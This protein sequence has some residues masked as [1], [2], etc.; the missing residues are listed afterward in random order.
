MKI[1]FLPIF[2]FGLLFAT[3]GLTT[4]CLN[5]D[6]TEI[7][8]SS[9][10]SITAFSLGTLKVKVVGK[11]Q[12][13]KDS[14]YYSEV[15]MSNYPFTIDQ[16]QRTIENKDS[17]PVGTDISRVITSITADTQYVLYGKISKKGEEPTDTLWTSTDSINFEVAPEE[18]L[19]FKV[20]AMSG[21]MGKPY[22]VKLNV[23]TL[24]PDSLQWASEPTHDQFTAGKLSHQKAVFINN[25]IFVFGKQNGETAVEYTRI[26]YPVINDQGVVVAPQPSAWEAV[27]NPQLAKADPYSATVWKEQIYFLSEGSLYILNPENLSVSQAAGT[28]NRTDLTQVLGSVTTPSGI[29]QLYARTAEGF[30][31]YTE[32]GQ[33][34]GWGNTE[35]APE[36]APANGER[37]AAATLPMSYNKNLMRTIVMSYNSAQKESAGVINQRLT[38]DNQWTAYNY[39]QID[40]FT[41]PNI[42]DGSMIFYNKKLYAFGGAVS[43]KKHEAYKDAFSTFYASTD[44]GL[45]WTPEVRYV[46][47]PENQ[48]FATYYQKGTAGE[49][50]Y[51]CVTDSYHFIW[52]IWADGTMSRGRINHLG[53][54]SKW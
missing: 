7:T 19:T 35:A 3:A 54:A 14:V 32:N 51:S 6:V 37:F 5:S 36:Y 1:K 40:T 21:V 31:T 10:T 13:G 11:D 16:I 41:C 39:A 4:S 20:G 42:V 27:S 48:S 49:G 30:I 46:R 23:H 2:I 22:H 17:L 29:S 44:N 24:V 52:I 50:A 15:D 38:N 25:R 43:S 26:T 12:A 53:L 34:A 28:L 18:G 9:N 45:T 8:Y 33:T 47:F